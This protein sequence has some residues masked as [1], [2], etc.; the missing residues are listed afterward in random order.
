MLDFLAGDQ[1]TEKGDHHS[2]GRY[3][4]YTSERRPHLGQIEPKH[5]KMA[6]RI[7]KIFLSVRR[8]STRQSNCTQKFCINCS[9]P[10]LYKV[11]SAVSKGEPIQ[12][13]LPAFP[14]KSPNS[15]KVLGPL[16]DMAELQALKF[17]QRL[18]G[19]VSLI[20]PP[21]AKITLCSDGRVFSDCV[22]IK[23]DD[24]TAYQQEIIRIIKRHQFNALLTFDL[25]VL[26]KE[27]S[28]SEKR[29]RLLK[30]FGEPLEVLKS[31]VAE[32]GHP[33]CESSEAK[34]TRELYC[35]I[36]RFLV[37]DMT[38]AGQPLSRSAIQRDSRQR[39]YKVIQMSKAWGDFVESKFP[40][41]VRLSIH[42]QSCGSAKLGIRMLQSE[43]W[44][45]PWHGVAVAING[46]FQLFKR[47]QA[48]ALGAKLQFVDGRPSHYILA[49]EHM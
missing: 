46:K 9:D 13:V 45:T 27:K 40:L 14:G 23:D 44:L 10:H 43:Q 25:D 32:G 31:S 19:E 20:Y 24:V 12:F 37:E 47:H 2:S 22:G 35:G 29:M 18:C 4:N 26:Y 48:E 38:F 3:G 1:G 17:L 15:S 42:P 16:P 36:T 30:E 39:A 5:R 8:M 7:L 11:A 49:S 41:A 33:F 34:N 21:G 6:L 28:F